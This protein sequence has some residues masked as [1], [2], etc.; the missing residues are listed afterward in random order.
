MNLYVIQEMDGNLFW[1]NTDGWTV[2]DYATIFTETEWELLHLPIDGVWR[3][4][5][6]SLPFDGEWKQRLIR[7]N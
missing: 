3:L 5:P 4:L 6:L 7:D 2:L 1:D